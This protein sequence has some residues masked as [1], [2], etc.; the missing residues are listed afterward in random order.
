MFAVL[1]RTV[2]L[3]LKFSKMVIKPL[4][5]SGMMAVVSYGVY[6][7]L[8]GIIAQNLATI[9]ALIVAVVTYA[10]SIIVLKIFNEEDILMLP[11]GQKIYAV[12]NKAGIY[13][14]K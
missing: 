13:K 8:K 14:E 9:I 2:N 1:K 6:I 3:K 7:L 11:Y 10:L 4:L 5:A 12:L